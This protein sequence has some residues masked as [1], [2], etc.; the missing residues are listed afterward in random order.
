MANLNKQISSLALIYLIIICLKIIDI[1]YHE[2][3]RIN[4][5]IIYSRNLSKIIYHSKKSP[6]VRKKNNC[7]VIIK[8][9]ILKIQENFEWFARKHHCECAW[10]AIKTHIYERHSM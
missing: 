3:T 9:S 10:Y 8:Q 7:F 6:Q 4:R 2:L 5:I 1:F